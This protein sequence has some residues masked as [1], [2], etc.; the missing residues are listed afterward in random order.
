MRLDNFTIKGQEA[1]EAAANLATDSGHQ[2]IEPDHLLLAL[3]QQDQ[4]T[5]PAIIEKLEVDRRILRA[6]A[7]KNLEGIPRVSGATQQYLSPQLNELLGRAQKEAEKFRDQFVSTEHL[8]LAL[9]ESK[10]RSGELLRKLGVQRDQVLKVLQGIRGSQTI[11]DQNPEDKY[12]ALARYSKDYTDL[13]RKGKLDPVIGR[14]DEIRRVVQVLSRRTK[15]NPLL[16]GEPGVGK[17]AIVEG[18][19]QRIIS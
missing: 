16:I 13:A 14:D 10:T 15:N 17:T 7:E 1:V 9:A 3:L 6:E 18:L 19:A 12:Q 11:T 4:G 2:Q 8:L 5:V